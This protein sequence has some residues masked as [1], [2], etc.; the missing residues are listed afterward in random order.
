MGIDSLVMVV[1][2]LMNAEINEKM[3]GSGKETF[4]RKEVNTML[5]EAATAVI[6]T[7]INAKKQAEEK[8][9]EDIEKVEDTKKAMEIMEKI[10]TG[11]IQ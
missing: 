6:E 3:I 2:L 10:H 1:T 4:T 7:T 9:K 5:A 8:A 11:K